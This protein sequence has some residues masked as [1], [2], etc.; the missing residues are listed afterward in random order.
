MLSFTSATKV[1]LVSGAT[2]MRKQFDSLAGL[3]RGELG[4]DPLSG[5]VFVFSNRRR[6]LI[7]LIFFDDSGF[8][9]CTKRLERG[10]YSWPESSEKS[11]EM[12]RD[13]L[14]V[15]LAGIDLRGARRRRWY[16]HA[17]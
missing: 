11:F 1:Y 13:E 14:A 5:H 6:N 15:L 10:T 8:W 7:R 4:E 2:D 12:S 16:E 17:S 9:C 3:V